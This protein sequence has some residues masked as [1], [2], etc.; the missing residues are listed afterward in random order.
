MNISSRRIEDQRTHPN[1][2][3]TWGRLLIIFSIGYSLGGRCGAG[4]FGGGFGGCFGSCFGSYFGG[5]FGGCVGVILGSGT[6]RLLFSFLLIDW[7]HE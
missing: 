1:C 7:L 6:G 3:T 5:Y 2:S 4:S